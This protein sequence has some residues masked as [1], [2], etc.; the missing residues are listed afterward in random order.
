M[1]CTSFDQIFH[2]LSC[3]FSDCH[4]KW[5][6]QKALDAQLGNILDKIKD[7]SAK[8]LSQVL[9]NLNSVDFDLESIG[10][11]RHLLGTFHSFNFQVE[12]LTTLGVIAL[13]LF[14]SLSI[15]GISH[16]KVD[17]LLCIS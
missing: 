11:H 16:L 9:Q 17:I 5:E 13:S 7:S 14:F 6:S 2:A 15:I 4:C 10:V 1:V 8:V 12:H 3:F